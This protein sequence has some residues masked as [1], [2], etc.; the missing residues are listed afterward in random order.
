MLLSIHLC[1]GSKMLLLLR[2]R[3]PS[4]RNQSDDNNDD[5]DNDDDND[6]EVIKD[7]GNS[8]GGD[9]NNTK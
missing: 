3:V 8:F 6:D 1:L 7:P 4:S 9:I 5:D 2:P